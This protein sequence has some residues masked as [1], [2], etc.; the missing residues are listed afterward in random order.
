MRALLFLL[1]AIT[2]LKMAGDA[3]VSALWRW[4]FEC[5]WCNMARLLFDATELKS[6]W[7]STMQ[8]YQKLSMLQKPCLF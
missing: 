6:F 7:C 2:T 5:L 4:N 8:T 3:I 1:H